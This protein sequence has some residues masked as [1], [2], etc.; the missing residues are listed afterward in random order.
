M[1][2]MSRSKNDTT[3][4]PTGD[5]GELYPVGGGGRPDV[6]AVSRLANKIMTESHRIITNCSLYPKMKLFK[7]KIKY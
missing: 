1:H 5:P 3:G 4:G 6:S 7:P 2:F